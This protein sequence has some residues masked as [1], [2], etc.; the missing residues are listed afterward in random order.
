MINLLRYPVLVLPLFWA[1]VFSMACGAFSPPSPTNT[2]DIPGTVNAA[3][4]HAL[5]TPVIQTTAIRRGYCGRLCDGHD[6][7]RSVN[8]SDVQKEL[9]SGV[10][11]HAIDEL[12]WA[13]IHKAAV[14]GYRGI[15]S[16]LLDAGADA[17]V[18]TGEGATLMYLALTGNF[19][20]PETVALLLAHGADVNAVGL[21]EGPQWTPLH[22]ASGN[23]HPASY[24]IVQILL[25]HGADI[26]A[27]DKTGSMPLHVASI[28]ADQNVISLLLDNGASIHDRDRQQWTPLHYS[29]WSDKPGNVRLLLDRG[30]DI[31]AR[32]QEGQT[33][34]QEA[35]E[36]HNICRSYYGNSLGSVDI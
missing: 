6:Y 18:R 3:V 5:G 34:C 10:D 31:S 12:G 4:A 13:P 1:T 29:S 8:L 22:W 19:A 7:W 26:K 17:D 35:L 23:D 28:S 32:D 21:L 24:D 27:K 20:D 36:R 16:L 14:Y 30:A 33:P 15:V 25:D 11:V 9:D 2:P